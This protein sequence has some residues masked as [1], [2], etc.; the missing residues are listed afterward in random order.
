MMLAKGYPAE[1]QETLVR[2][3]SSTEDRFVEWMMREEFGVGKESDR[4]PKTAMLVVMAAF[5]AGAALPVVP[6]FV[7]T[8]SRALLLASLLS[9]GGLF[10][11]GWGKARVAGLP[12]IR[13]GL[14]MAG[15]GTLAA[16]VTYGVG[17]LFDVTA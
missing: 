11:A 5:V 4:S 2:H 17:S 12:G 8:G 3:I 14:E 6:F 1:V 10:A 16:L 15:L 13:S 9:L 7:A